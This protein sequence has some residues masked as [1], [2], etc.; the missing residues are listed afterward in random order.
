MKRH[1]VG[2]DNYCL[3]P[4]NLMPGDM[5]SWALRNGA[6]GISF[7]GYEEAIRERFTETY[8]RDIRRLA[9]DNGLYVEWGNG[10]HIPLDLKSF[11]P[12]DI[13][14]SNRRAVKEARNLGARII[15]SCSGGLMRWN[16]DSPSTE[17]ILQATAEELRN[18]ES[19]FCDHEIT[20]AIETHFEFTTFELVRIFEMCGARPGGWL[21]ICLDTMNLLTM[22]EEP[23]EAT[24]RI[25]P[26]IVST[27]IK[28]GGLTY[29]EEG[30][31]TFPVALGSGIIDFD[32]IISKIFS[33]GRDINLSV[34][35]HGGSFFLPVN[36]N[37]FIEKFPDLTVIEYE[38]LVELAEKTDNKKDDGN[39]KIT[40]RE[41]WPTICENRTQAD[42]IKLK[43]IRAQL[44][45]T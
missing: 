23:V 28:D 29:N 5:I 41:A 8:L 9:A 6:E 15:R 44:E 3:Y 37:W 7:S 25:L 36:E 16:K 31:T 18:H 22:L 10:Q 30:I 24:E 21:G 13:F 35:C 26:W 1:L 39:M 17:S 12:K 34:E 4:L 40:A 43:Q 19:L 27:H 42:I 2:L 38:M 45:K 14:S 11:S 20:L 32:E 33:T